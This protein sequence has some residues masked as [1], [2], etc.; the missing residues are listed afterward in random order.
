MRDIR[1]QTGN[2][3]KNNSLGNLYT[4]VTLEL[5]QCFRKSFIILQAS[6]GRYCLLLY[7]CFSVLEKALSSYRPHKVDTVYFY[8]NTVTEPS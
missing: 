3:V 6:Q 1:D 4:A 7:E 2:A 8:M 5:L